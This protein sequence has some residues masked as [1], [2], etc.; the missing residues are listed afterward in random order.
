MGLPLFPQQRT[1]SA[2]PAM[3]EKC[4]QATSL[5]FDH[6]VGAGKQFAALQYRAPGPIAR[7]AS[8]CTDAA[9]ASLMRHVAQIGQARTSKIILNGVSVARRKRLKP[10]SVATWRNLP[11][12]A[13]APSPSPTHC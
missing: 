13:C 6:L 2:Q 10:A 9:D 5:L 3:S 4:Q 8:W 11:S 1:S 7:N 12:P